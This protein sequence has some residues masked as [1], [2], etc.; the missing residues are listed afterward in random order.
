MHYETHGMCYAKIKRSP[1]TKGNSFGLAW[2]F[3]IWLGMGK[4]GDKWGELTFLLMNGGIEPS[5][6]VG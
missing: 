4:V 3:M 6:R 5:K 1:I 2:V